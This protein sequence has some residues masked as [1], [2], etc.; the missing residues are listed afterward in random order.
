[1]CLLASGTWQSPGK[2]PRSSGPTEA[3]LLPLEPSQVLVVGQRLAL[4]GQLQ[5]PLLLCHLPLKPPH[6]P[7]QLCLLD[8][9]GTSQLLHFHCEVTEASGT[10]HRAPTAWNPCGPHRLPVE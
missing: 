9:P 1:M 3:D 5:V 6:V 4:Q 7:L 2:R 8:L 10:G